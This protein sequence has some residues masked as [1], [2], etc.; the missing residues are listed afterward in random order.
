MAVFCAGKFVD[1]ITFED[2]QP[3]FRQ[4]V[5]VTDSNRIH[6]LIVIPI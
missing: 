1:E 2:G 6:T 3:K 4:R 5:V